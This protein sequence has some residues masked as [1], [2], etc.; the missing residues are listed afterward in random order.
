M[1]EFEGIKAGNIRVYESFFKAN[2]KKVSR[3]AYKMVREETIAEEITQEVFIYIW[4][5]RDKINITD[6]LLSYVFAAVRNRCI[7]YIKL[8]LPKQRSMEDIDTIEIPT[9][10]DGLDPDDLDR[11]REIIDRCIQALPEKC[12]EIFVLSR[13]GGLTYDEI[14]EDM[15]LSVKTVENQMGIALKKLRE[16]LRPLLNS[17]KR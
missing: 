12:R 2:Y 3:F 9:G 7:N 8:E 4:D 10:E 15:E 6:S 11:T 16:S 1:H 5:K 14:A 17:L 13:Y